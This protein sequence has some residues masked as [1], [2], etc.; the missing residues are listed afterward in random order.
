M[1]QLLSG[2]TARQRFNLLMIGVFAVVALGLASVGLYGVMSYLVSQRTREIGIRIALGGQPG[3]VRRMVVRESL[4]ISV[5]GLLAGAAV[6][7]AL[8]SI[9]GRV[10][11]GVRPTDPPTCIAIVLLLLLV[12]AAA[13][14][15]PA[16]RATRVDPLVA[17]RE[18]GT[19]RP[20]AQPDR[21][22]S[23]AWAP[24]GGRAIPANAHQRVRPRA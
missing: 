4:V 3:D 19:G 23:L 17:L 11:F 8:S 16:R 21:P 1:D 14:N 22:E 18:Y 13:S 24:V 5:S 6:S 10:L 2:A 20:A 7:L 9:I 12:A 15:G